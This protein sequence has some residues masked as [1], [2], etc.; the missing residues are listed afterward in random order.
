MQIVLGVPERVSEVLKVQ[1]AHFEPV[2]IAIRG[3]GVFPAVVLTLPRMEDAGFA[4]ALRQAQ[5]QQEH[6]MAALRCSAEGTTV[7]STAAAAEQQVQEQHEHI[8][9]A[10]RCKIKK[11][12]LLM[13]PALSHCEGT[14]KLSLLVSH[15]QSEAAMAALHLP[16]LR[17]HQ[18]ACVPSSSQHHVQPR[19]P[20]SAVTCCVQEYLP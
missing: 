3:E 17:S 9:A 10:V 18:M 15:L 16:L 8:A 20:T 4:V 14:S 2:P 1:I 6:T 13:L 12:V 11:Q 5:E 19:Q 7:H